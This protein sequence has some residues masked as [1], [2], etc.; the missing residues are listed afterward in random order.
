[1][2]AKIYRAIAL[3]FFVLGMVVFS[4]LYQK[5]F[6]QDFSKALRNPLMIVLLIFPFMPAIV[7]TLITRRL[8]IKL[9]KVF[10][11]EE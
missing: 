3:M 1:M 5:E 2:K 9:K 4:L 8:E 7:F 10:T 6:A 11:E